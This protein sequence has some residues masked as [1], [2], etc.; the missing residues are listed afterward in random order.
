MHQQPPAN[1]LNRLRGWILILLYGSL[2]LLCLMLLY[3]LFALH[4]SFPEQ[5][6]AYY[7]TVAITSIAAVFNGSACFNHLKIVKAEQPLPR[8]ALKPFLLMAL[9]LLLVGRLFGS[10]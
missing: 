6:V 4:G 8:L 1:D 2:A 7:G 5:M 10:M 9:T 3:A